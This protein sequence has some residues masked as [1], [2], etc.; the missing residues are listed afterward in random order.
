MIKEYNILCAGFR[1]TTYLFGRMDSSR[2]SVYYSDLIWIKAIYTQN[3]LEAEQEL[4]AFN[5]NNDREIFGWGD[6]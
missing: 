6:F 2:D 1:A 4:S 5:P 3:I